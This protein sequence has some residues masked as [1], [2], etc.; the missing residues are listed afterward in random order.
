MRSIHG[1][2]TVPL[3]LHSF[4]IMPLGAPA[5]RTGA[6]M[7]RVSARGADTLRGARAQVSRRVPAPVRVRC[8]AVW[9]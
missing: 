9:G 2:V 8:G 5:A 6:P 1:S 3:A 4:T 7:A